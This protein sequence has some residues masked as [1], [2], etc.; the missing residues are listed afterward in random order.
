MSKT[1]LITSGKNWVENTAIMQLNGLT[2][3]KGVVK[4]VGL[5]DLHAGKTPIGVAVV[6]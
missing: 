2:T 6:T 5:P 3:L 4:A 1:L